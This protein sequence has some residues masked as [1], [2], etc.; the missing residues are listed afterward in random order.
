MVSDLLEIVFQISHY[1]IYEETEKKS[2]VWDF[3]PNC[4][5]TCYV[6]SL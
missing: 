3:T 4:T 6:R 2:L 1:I 5:W